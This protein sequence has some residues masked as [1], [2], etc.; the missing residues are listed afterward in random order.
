M[1][2]IHAPRSGDSV[3]G[4]QLRSWPLVPPGGSAAVGAMAGS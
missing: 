3:L 1:T 4:A 2:H